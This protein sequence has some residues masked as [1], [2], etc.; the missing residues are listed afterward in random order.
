MNGAAITG[1]A[2]VTFKE[3]LRAK[4][5]ISF[6][7]VFF[8]LAVNV[9][10]L[11]LL[12]LERLPPNYIDTFLALVVTLSFP[13]LPLLVLPMGATSVVEDRE[14]GSLQYVL[15][16]PVSRSDFLL[17]RLLGLLG[18]TTA[19]IIIGYGVAS[20]LAYN[21]R[22]S[23]YG[24]VLT[25]MGIAVILNFTV[26][27]I[28]FLISVVS[29]RKATA[30]GAALFLWFVMTLISDT[31]ST[32]VVLS[33]IRNAYYALPLIV[34]NPV[35]AASVLASCNSTSQTTKSGSLSPPKCFWGRMRIQF[36]H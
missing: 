17:G 21:A 10:T 30:L 4:W 11:T 33:F 18:A 14:S 32:G 2:R 36:S 26:L 19:V 12:L 24:L 3:S 16:N 1:I 5:L 31:S 7:L 6:S 22:L 13:Y 23:Q 35:Q 9:P 28:S 34:G 25:L 27:C 29:K 20:V 15:S 8:L